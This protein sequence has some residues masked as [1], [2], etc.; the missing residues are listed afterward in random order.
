MKKRVSLEKNHERIR[1]MCE[2][3]MCCQEIADAI[4]S[5]D[6]SMAHYL[7]KH[8]LKATRKKPPAR[9]TACS[10]QH[11]TVKAMA[12]AGATLQSTAE[13]VGTTH[14][15]VSQYLQA[16]GIERP[17]WRQPPPE[18]HPMARRTDGALN[19]QWKGGRMRDKDGYVLLWKPGHPEANRHGYVREHRIV[20]ARTIGRP[21]RPGEVVDHINDIRDD[22]RPV[23]LRVFASNGEHLS[24]TLTGRKS[25]ES[26]GL[27]PSTRTVSGTG[28]RRSP[29]SAGRP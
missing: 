25:R 6:A 10:R 4:G 11:E 17:A 3:G 22:N 16:Q 20:M 18:A 7:R 28:G 13:V 5:S 29:S 26:R 2:Q 1:R 23:N 9:P 14:H 8:S 12:E 19:P 15:R 21:L 27:P 24:A